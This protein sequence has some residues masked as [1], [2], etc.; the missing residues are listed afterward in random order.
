[1]DLA[2]KE[3]ASKAGNMGDLWQKSKA[4]NRNLYFLEQC[5]DVHRFNLTNSAGESRSIPYRSSKVPPISHLSFPEHDAHALVTCSGAALT[6]R[7]GFR[8]V[9]D[10]LRFILPKA[11]RCERKQATCLTQDRLTLV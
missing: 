11:H 6:C 2:G 9:A 10:G 8:S 3:S 4:N 7:Q 5:I 1:M